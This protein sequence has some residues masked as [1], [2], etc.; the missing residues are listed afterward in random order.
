MKKQDLWLITAKT[1]IHVG[2]EN[3]SSYGL[4]DKAI[5]RDVLTKLP[6]INSS[7]LKGA[8]NENA[9]YDLKLS[10][11][12]RIKVFGVDKTDSK[13]ETSKGLYT[14]FDAQLLLLPIP[15]DKMLYELITSEG[16]L[17]RFVDKV[18]SFGVVVSV[19][20]LKAELRKIGYTFSIKS[21]EEFIDYCSDYNLPIIARNKLVNGQSDNLWYEQVLPAE[22]VFY[23]LIDNKGD[24]VLTDKLDH[25]IVQ[26]G[27][28]ATIGYGYCKFTNLK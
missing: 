23:T 26:I 18:N 5:Q 21:D 17:K 8:L 16:V 11:D 12:E 2:N 9:I 6:C 19:E 15:S 13:K 20:D 7:S 3:T 4:I 10:S 24:A 28:N 25:K 14:F 27:A 1:N 22:S